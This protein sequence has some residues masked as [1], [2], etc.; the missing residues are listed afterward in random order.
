MGM[1]EEVGV[2]A[3]ATKEG[4]PGMMETATTEV[5]EVTA[6][7]AS[8]MTIVTAEIAKVMRERTQLAET[9]GT[10]SPRTALRH[11]PP[12]RAVV[13]PEAASRGPNPPRAEKSRTHA[14]G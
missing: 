7:G 5:A 1:E 11:L 14:T 8:A 10:E 3:A 2:A 9:R 13:V 4:A 12:A 6:V